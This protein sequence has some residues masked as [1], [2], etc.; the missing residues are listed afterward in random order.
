MKTLKKLL[1]RT[2]TLFILFFTQVSLFA[3]GE[4][5]KISDNDYGNSSVEMADIFRQDGKIYVVL[6]VLLTIFVGIII[7]L[8]MTERKIAALEKKAN[9]LNK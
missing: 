5:I 8:V 4:K 1:F 2:L 9:L 6:A 7:F 3:Q